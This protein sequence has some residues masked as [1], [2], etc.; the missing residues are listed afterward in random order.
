LFEIN[1]ATQGVSL[2]HFHVC[3]YN[4]TQFGSSPIFLHSTLA[5]FLW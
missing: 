3:V 5:P 1:V 2:W 4:I